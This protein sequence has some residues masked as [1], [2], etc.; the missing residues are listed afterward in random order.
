MLRILEIRSEIGAGTRGAS[1]GPEAIKMASLNLQNDLFSRYPTK[2]VPN[3]NELLFG[4]VLTPWGKRIEGLYKVFERYTSEVQSSFKKYDHLITLAGDHST[5]AATIAGIRMSHPNKRLGVI[6]IDAHADLHSPYSTPSG[7]LHGMPLG[8]SLGID[9]LEHKEH[10]PVKTTKEYWEKLKSIG[11]I[12]PKINPNDLVFIGV[13]DTEEAEKLAMKNQKIKN[14]EVDEVRKIGIQETIRQTLEQLKDCDI[15]YVSFDVDS[16]DPAFS[17]GTGTPVEGGF[18]PEEV[19]EL[20]IGLV[21]DKKTIAF[22]IVE[23]NPCLDDKKNT[24]AEIAFGI[25]N[26][27]VEVLE[28]K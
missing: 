5:A 3:E 19:N 27:V 16:M 24:M 4:P 21:K 10:E 6:W 7:N 25:L 1:L 9:N 23:V 17:R 22:E 15:L 14:F 12:N 26:N 28:K 13:R 8:I 20:I 18:N 11:G 2:E